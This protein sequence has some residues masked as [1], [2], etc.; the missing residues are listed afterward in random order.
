MNEG[1]EFA[2]RDFRQH[3]GKTAKIRTHTAARRDKAV[4]RQNLERQR[5]AIAGRIL[6]LDFKC[7]WREGLAGDDRAVARHRDDLPAQRGHPPRNAAANADGAATSR[8]HVAKPRTSPAVAIKTL[9][10]KE[11]IDESLEDG[12]ESP[13]HQWLWN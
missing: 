11:P 12:I 10:V 8:Q 6:E 7:A 1:S 4:R 3:K 5:G 13:P 2:P 9:G